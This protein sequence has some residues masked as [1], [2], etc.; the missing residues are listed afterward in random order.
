MYSGQRDYGNNWT[1]NYNANMALRYMWLMP[2]V[3]MSTA[4]LHPTV[5]ILKIR[6]QNENCEA[7]CR[8]QQ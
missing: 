4:Y 2:D 1:A 7:Q 3:Q 6:K 5:D 8:Y